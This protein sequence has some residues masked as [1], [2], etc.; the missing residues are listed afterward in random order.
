MDSVEDHPRYVC[1]Y[2]SNSKKSNAKRSKV[3]K[4][5]ITS[6]RLRKLQ[7]RRNVKNKKMDT[8]ITTTV[9][10]L[11]GQREDSSLTSDLKNLHKFSS[12]KLKEKGK[13]CERKRD[14]TEREGALCV[15]DMRY[16]D[17][18]TGTVIR[19][20]SKIKDTPIR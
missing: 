17:T 8:K 1:T 14:T 13:K 10:N 3:K 5:K 15:T 6:K 11:G 7:K 2:P 20:L 16:G 12:E 18:G 4:R 9:M 19:H